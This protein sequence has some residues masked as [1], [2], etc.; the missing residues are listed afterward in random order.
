VPTQASV[1]EPD[2]R[3]LQLRAEEREARRLEKK[4]RDV[5]LYRFGAAA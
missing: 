5:A 4:L 2:R 3:A 1:A